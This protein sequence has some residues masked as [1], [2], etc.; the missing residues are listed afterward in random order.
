[1]QVL[2]W[3]VFPGGAGTYFITS[4]CARNFIEVSM[5]HAFSEAFWDSLAALPWLLL[6]YVL[7]EFIEARYEGLLKKFVA[8]SQGM[9]PLV[10]ALLGC[11]PQCGFSMVASALYCHR[12]ITLGTLL[13]VYL[14]TS[15]EAVPVI[16]AQPDKI[17][18][19]APLLFSKVVI[20][21]IA[22]FA[23]DLFSARFGGA[24]SNAHTSDCLCVVD[25]H[26]CGHKHDHSNPPWK[27]ILLSP[28]IHALQ[29]SLFILG[30]S[31]ALNIFVHEV[32]DA[33]I[34]SALL[35]NSVLQPLIMVIVGLIPNCAA[36]VVITQL[37]LKGSISFGSAVA[38]LSSSAGL[39]L[40]VLVKEIPTLGEAI[41]II[42]LL[43][44]ISFLAGVILNQ[45]V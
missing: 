17:G 36:S 34:A 44:S 4:L 28:A 6:I 25:A 8:G 14:S 35:G 45:F 15:D 12:N 40:I 20:A 9:G 22:G 42:V 38:G 13:A 11:L 18:V 31:F 19:L 32:G 29:I 3:E 2:P 26:C 43:A 41:R 5:W 10:G 7:F 21:M 27:V 16:L 24:S 33:A 39:G 30:V 23:V 1:M 37:L